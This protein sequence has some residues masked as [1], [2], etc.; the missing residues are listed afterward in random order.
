MPL[1]PLSALSKLGFNLPDPSESAP[2]EPGEDMPGSGPKALDVP[3]EALLGALGVGADTPANR[4][5]A[6]LG[7]AGP[8]IGRNLMGPHP[9]IRAL[10]DTLAQ[11]PRAVSPARK[12]LGERV[13]SYQVPHRSLIVPPKGFE[14]PPEMQPFTGR[15]PT[16]IQAYADRRSGLGEGLAKD[17]NRL[18]NRRSSSKIKFKGYQYGLD[19]TPGGFESKFA[20]A[21]LGPLEYLPR[22]KWGKK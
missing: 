20:V 3:I 19:E 13:G 1:H 6:L 16:L 4:G 10:M 14:F 17:Y 5:G 18:G 11:E 9:A 8:V 12:F 2:L 15:D 21:G 22:P 7:A